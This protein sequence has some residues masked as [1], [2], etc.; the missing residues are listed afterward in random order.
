MD[1]AA[2]SVTAKLL[3]TE[4]ITVVQDNVRTAMFDVKNRVLTLPMWA[5]V[6]PYTEDHLIGHEV[7][8]A[9]YTPLE[10]WHDA[11]C[12]KGAGYKSFLNVVHSPVVSDNLGCSNLAR[13]L[14]QALASGRQ[15]P[16]HTDLL[17]KRHVSSSI[18]T[19][20]EDTKRLLVETTFYQLNQQCN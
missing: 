6:A 1:Q 12:S 19:Q 15:E 11:V 4:N 5:D 13:N 20:S 7:G 3:A 9:L 18:L 14:Y 10:G 17:D 8:H 2:K 16:L